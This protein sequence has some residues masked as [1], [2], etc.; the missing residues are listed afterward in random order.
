LGLNVSLDSIEITSDSILVVTLLLPLRFLRCSLLGLLFRNS[1][2]LLGLRSEISS[3]IVCLFDVLRK[4]KDTLA[5]TLI[6]T[7]RICQAIAESIDLFSDGRDGS[8]VVLL[9]SLQAIALLL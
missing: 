3:S 1:A 9:V 6:T 8:L 2:Q 7:T 4:L 5:L